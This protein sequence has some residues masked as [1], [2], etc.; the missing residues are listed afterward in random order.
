MGET[1]KSGCPLSL[2]IVMGSTHG[3]Q[4]SDNLKGRHTDPGHV[5]PFN[6]CSGGPLNLLTTN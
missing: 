6:K 3:W 5:S 1:Q 2:P 4:L